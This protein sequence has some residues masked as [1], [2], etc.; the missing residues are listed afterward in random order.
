MNEQGE[1]TE[2]VNLPTYSTPRW[3][4]VF[5]VAAIVL[6]LLIAILMPTGE[7]GPSRHIPS[8]E[9]TTTMEHEG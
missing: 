9:A 1:T 3:V 8:A 2:D 6:V 5:G 4:K 7:H